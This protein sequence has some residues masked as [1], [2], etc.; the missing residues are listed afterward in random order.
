V[1]QWHQTLQSST[2]TGLWLTLITS[3]GTAYSSSDGHSAGFTFLYLN[4]HFILSY[5]SFQVQYSMMFLR[6]QSLVLEYVLGV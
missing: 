1:R 5:C 6:D 2:V 3:A 4:L